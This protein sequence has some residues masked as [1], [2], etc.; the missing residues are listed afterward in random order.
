LKRWIL[1]L[2]LGLVAVV[3][4]LALPPRGPAS[5]TFPTAQP[6]PTIRPAV[7]DVEDYVR[8]YSGLAGAYRSI[9]AETSCAKLQ[10]EFYTATDNHTL[11]F[12]A[13]IDDRAR[14]LGCPTLKFNRP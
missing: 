12:Q 6:I 5:R 11:G 2:V 7:R 8:V 3:G 10:E 4:I 13:A 1:I 9:L 14:D